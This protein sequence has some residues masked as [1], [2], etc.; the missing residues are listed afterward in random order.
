MPQL[1]QMLCCTPVLKSQEFISLTGCDGNS[2]GQDDITVLHFGLVLGPSE[3]LFGG[4]R[5]QWAVVPSS[6]QPGAH[7]QTCHIIPQTFQYKWLVSESF[8]IST[9]FMIAF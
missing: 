6:G 4:G 8:S 5:G 1:R 9:D 3:Q 7:H 2:T